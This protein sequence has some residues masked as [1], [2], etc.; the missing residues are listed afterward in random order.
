[1]TFGFSWLGAALGLAAGCGLLLVAAGTRRRR[2]TLVERLAAALL[3][4]DASCGL[5]VLPRSL[6]TFVEPWLA[7]LAAWVERVGS[8]REQLRRRLERAGRIEGPEA[9]RAQQLTWTGGGLTVGLG[10]A[11][12]ARLT[13]DLGFSHLALLV[14]GGAVSGFCASGQALSRQI[15]AREARM[16]AEFPTIAELLALAVTAGEPPAAALGRVAATVNGDLAAE[17]GRVLGD[18]H[19]GRRLEHA[20]AALAARVELAP[21]TRFIAGITVALERGTPLAEVLRAQAADVR[22]AARRAL[23]DAGGRKEVTM[24]VPVIF[25]VLPVTVIFAIFPSLSTLTIGF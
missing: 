18:V 25:L 14:V 17:I 7:A 12:F 19:S 1:M 3:P 21:I 8:P 10:L 22:E 5:L 11:L 16:L 2:I 23:L 20:L 9:Y 6:A 24:L 4:R 13:G 15:K